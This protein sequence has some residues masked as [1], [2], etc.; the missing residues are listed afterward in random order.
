MNLIR[1]LSKEVN[2]YFDKGR[3]QINKVIANDDY[4]L[5]ITFDNGEVKIYNL[6]KRFVTC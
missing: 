3:R 4:S 5:T 6:S 2:N 1:G